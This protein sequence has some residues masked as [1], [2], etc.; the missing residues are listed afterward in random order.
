MHTSQSMTRVLE[1]K[2]KLQ[3]SKKGG[4]TYAQYI[5]LMQ[6]LAD[7]VHSIG[8]DLSDQDLVLYTLQTLLEFE[9]LP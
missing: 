4:S 5:K 2:L 9:L 1:L 8:A 6:G 3:T 7:R